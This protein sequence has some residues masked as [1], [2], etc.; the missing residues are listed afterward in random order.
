MNDMKTLIISLLIFT[1]LQIVSGQDKIITI[2]NDTIHCRIVAFSPTHIQYEQKMENRR[3]INKFIPMDQVSVYFRNPQ[4]TIEINTYNRTERQKSKPAHRWMGGMQ[5]GGSFSMASS[6][7][8]WRSQTI[9]NLGMTQVQVDHFNKQFK[10]GWHLNGDIHYMDTENVG[11]GVKYSFFASSAQNDF[12]VEVYSEEIPTYVCVGMKV[13][14]YIHYAGPSVIFRQWLGNQ[15]KCQ[16]T[17]ML[18]VGYVGYRD[19]FRIDATFNFDNA[20]IKGNTWGVNCGM[21][22]DYF[23]KSWLSVGANAGFMYARL[24]ELQISDKKSTQTGKLDSKYYQSLARI[25]C[26]LGIR[27]IF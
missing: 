24:T 4:S 13:N 5:T 19:E 8:S 21:S 7:E 12:F 2:Q 18:S 6:D 10:L 15:Q 17:E 27:F 22:F 23:L 16:L 11:L 1:S 9:N 25:D 26:S 20:L 3:M 14:Q